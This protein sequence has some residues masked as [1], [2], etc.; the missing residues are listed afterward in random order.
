M[1]KSDSSQALIEIESIELEWQ[2]LL[3]VLTDEEKEEKRRENAKR[4][5]LILSREIQRLSEEMDNSAPTKG[6]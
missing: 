1:K 4:V 5:G 3:S 2:R 6:Q